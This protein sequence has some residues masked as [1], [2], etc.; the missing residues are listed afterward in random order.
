MGLLSLLSRG[1]PGVEDLKW[2]RLSQNRG[3]VPDTS[4]HNPRAPREGVLGC[5]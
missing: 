4:G 3:L 5:T 2:G 1:I